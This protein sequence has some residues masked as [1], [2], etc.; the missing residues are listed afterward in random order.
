ML[1]VLTEEENMEE[2]D[3]KENEGEKGGKGRG[4]DRQSFDFSVEQRNI[5]FYK[6]KNIHNYGRV[7]RLLRV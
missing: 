4:G 3:E 1:I 2:E 7:L 6:V 5:R